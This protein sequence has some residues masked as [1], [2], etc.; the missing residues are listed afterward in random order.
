RGRSYDVQR[1]DDK[2]TEETPSPGELVVPSGQHAKGPR[3]KHAFYTAMMAEIAAAQYSHPLHKELTYH[4]VY[5]KGAPFALTKDKMTQVIGH[6]SSRLNIFR[7]FPAVTAGMETLNADLYSQGVG[8]KSHAEEIVA[9]MQI[10][11]QAALGCDSD[12]PSLGGFT[13]YLHGT[14]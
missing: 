11:T 1:D 4:Y 5:A 8:T 2:Q 13:C 10:N 14:L 7:H 9:A 12:K 6:G 3:R